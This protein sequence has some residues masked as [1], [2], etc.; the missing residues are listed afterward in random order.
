MPKNNRPDPQSK[1]HQHRQYR[2]GCKP[3]RSFSWPNRSSRKSAGFR[4]CQYLQSPLAEFPFPRCGCSPSPGHSFDTRAWE[5]FGCTLPPPESCP[6][7]G[8]ER[9]CSASD[10]LL[11]QSCRATPFPSTPVSIRLRRV[12]ST[13]PAASPAPAVAAAPR[14]RLDATAF[15]SDPANTG[16][17][18]ISPAESMCPLPEKRLRNS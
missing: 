1:H 5:P 2:P 3:A 6:T 7:L 14:F 10:F 12:A 9:K 16:R 11:Q 18:R 13:T 4:H 8:A 17:I 15:A